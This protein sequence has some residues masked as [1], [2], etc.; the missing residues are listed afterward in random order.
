[1]KVYLIDRDIEVLKNDGIVILGDIVL[2]RGN[3]DK[4]MWMEK[5]LSIMLGNRVAIDTFIN[6]E[7]IWAERVSSYL[8]DSGAKSMRD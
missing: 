2:T 8:Q 5:L 6:N 1:M 7:I 3:V 4:G